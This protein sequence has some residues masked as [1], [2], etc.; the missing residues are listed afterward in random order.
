MSHVFGG[1]E[2]PHPAKAMAQFPNQ[3]GQHAVNV[4]QDAH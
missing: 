2:Q 1:G 4:N 3:I